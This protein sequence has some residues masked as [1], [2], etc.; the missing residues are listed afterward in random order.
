MILYLLLYLNIQ[1]YFICYF[2][3]KCSTI[4]YLL[5]YS[6]SIEYPDESRQTKVDLTLVFLVVHRV[7]NAVQGAE[8]KDKEKITKEETFMAKK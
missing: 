8:R 5:Q 1:Y 3:F 4:Y 6:R 2:T 7:D